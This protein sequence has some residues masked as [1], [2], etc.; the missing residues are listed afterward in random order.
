M[1]I[2]VSNGNKEVKDSRRLMPLDLRRHLST[3]LALIGTHFKWKILSKGQKF[4]FRVSLL[5]L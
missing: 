1:E 3:V 2:I 5:I 4:A